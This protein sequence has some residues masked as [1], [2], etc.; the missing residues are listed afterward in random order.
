LHTGLSSNIRWGL[1]DGTNLGA[2][3]SSGTRYARL[4]FT[5]I[6]N[7]FRDFEKSNESKI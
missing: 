1:E 5:P 2:M 6:E 7:S 4:L 3:P